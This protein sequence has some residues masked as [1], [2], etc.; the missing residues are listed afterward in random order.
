MSRN[1]GVSWITDCKFF[2]NSIRVVN[3]TIP[4]GRPTPFTLGS[5]IPFHGA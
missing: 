1:L 4:D 5:N 2:S 3:S